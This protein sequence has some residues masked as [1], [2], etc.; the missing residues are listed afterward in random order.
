MLSTSR[1]RI[2]ALCLLALLSLPGLAHE[3]WLEPL[4]YRLEPGEKLR[5]HIKVGQYFKGNTH[6]YL[7]QRFESFQLTLDD[8]TKPVEARL[9]T[10]PA[11]GQTVARQGLAI[12][13]YASTIETLTY[14]EAET[15]Q[16]FLRLDGL[17]WVRQAHQRRGLPAEGFTEAYRRFAKAYV[18]IGDARGEDRAFGFPI[19]WLLEDNPYRLAPDRELT[20]RLLW[21]GKPHGD[22][23]VRIFMRPSGGEQVEELRLHTDTEGRVRIP[24]RAT[25]QYLVSSVH[26]IEPEKRVREKT[27]AVW[28]SLWASAVFYR[29]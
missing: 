24:Y 19:E 12:L 27:G 13:T 10:T 8:E 1:L 20:A 9:G 22:S 7:P 15:F 28:Q 23:L 5:A 2:P 11:V 17:A 6:S 29:Q 3:F 14:D 4:D 18:G 25:T 21:H 16:N 26:M